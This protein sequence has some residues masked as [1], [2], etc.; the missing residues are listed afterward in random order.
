MTCIRTSV[1]W[2][3]LVTS[4]LTV[5][6]MAQ[7]RVFLKQG[8]PVTGAISKLT[9]AE[10]IIAVRGKDQTVSMKDVKKV[11][12][13][14]EPPVLD[15]ARDMAMD[16]RYAQAIEQLRTL[17]RDSL[18]DNPLIRQDYEFYYWFSEGSRS[19]A[20]SGDQ[21]AAIK[22]LMGFD[23][24]NPESHH[25]YTVK[26]LLG[27]LAVAKS[28]YDKAIEYFTDLG[29]SSDDTT[30]ATGVYYLARVRLEQGQAEV[31]KSQLKNLL[32]ANATS[33]EMGRVKSL[34]AVLDARCD[35]ELGNS[36]SA[37]QAL[38][39]LAMREDNSDFLLFAEINNARGAAYLKMNDPPRAAYSYLQTDLLFFT[40]P[41]SHAEALYHLKNLLVA[42]GQ[43]TKAAEASQRLSQQ[44]ASSAWANK[45]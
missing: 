36:E 14:K 20:G 30:K 43:P 17:K 22:G 40:D 10:V 2:V 37:L 44:Y 26:T 11:A 23:K 38:D 3:G 27:R 42:V 25:R 12:F 1:A 24:A 16:G 19:L 21:T 7:D 9:P 6:T 32:S 33:P 41:E 5:D 18:P 34:S 31:A 29:R 39:A 35:I 45:K 4:F 8:S 28:A 15:R 13:D